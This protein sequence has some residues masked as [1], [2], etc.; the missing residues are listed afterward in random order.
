MVGRIATSESSDG[1]GDEFVPA[2][3]SKSKGKQRAK[4][5]DIGNEDDGAMH[6]DVEMTPLETAAATKPTHKR[7]DAAPAPGGELHI[8]PCQQCANKEQ[9]CKKEIGGGACFGCTKLKIKCEY[10]GVKGQRALPRKTER[11]RRTSYNRVALKKEKKTQK[12]AKKKSK[13]VDVDVE[14]DKDVGDMTEPETE[15]QEEQ[16]RRPASPDAI[17][18]AHSSR[19]ATSVPPGNDLLEEC[20]CCYCMSNVCDLIAYS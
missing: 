1:S 13:W 10:S 16:R 14:S 20:E 9:P 5:S 19:P 8:P 18:P 11:R 2:A 7:R 6:S 3:L 15:A 12:V 17:G 4:R